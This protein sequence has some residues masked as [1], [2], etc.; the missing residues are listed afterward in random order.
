ML[1]AVASGGAPVLVVSPYAVAPVAP[2]VP[3]CVDEV[4]VSGAVSPETEDSPRRG[5]LIGLALAGLLIPGVIGG[6]LATAAPGYGQ[7]SVSATRYRAAEVQV[8]TGDVM[9][10]RARGGD[11][12]WSLA[13]RF[14]RDADGNGRL[15][16]GELNAYVKDMVKANGG[17]SAI[18]AGQTLRIP[19]TANASHEVALVTAAQKAYPASSADWLGARV[20]P[21]PMETFH[22]T[23]RGTGGFYVGDDLSGLQPDRY[24]VMREA[25]AAREFPDL[26]GVSALG[27]TLVQGRVSEDGATFAVP[28][29]TAR[30]VFAPDA[31]AAYDAHGTKLAAQ[32]VR[33]KVTTTTLHQRVD[34]ARNQ[35]LTRGPGGEVVLNLPA[36]TRTVRI[37][38]AQ[39]GHDG[40][41][42]ALDGASR[43]I[44]AEY[45]TDF[46]VE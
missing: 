38:N 14:A 36:G 24:I 30:L 35:L 37:N 26:F 28:A 5:R 1:S 3:S 15:S 34:V 17:R 39:A 45:N 27:Q 42:I 19:V 29:G 2:S 12:Y 43:Q 6:V 22:V 16:S 7:T 13:R 18:R 20:E 8:R 4:V 33:L 41:I 46:F 11:T 10:S 44:G 23:A 32:P 9:T 40:S 31:V 21:G 25:D